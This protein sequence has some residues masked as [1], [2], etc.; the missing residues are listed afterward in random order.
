VSRPQA[1]AGP[2]TTLRKVSGEGAS[3]GGWKAGASGASGEVLPKQAIWLLVV[4]PQA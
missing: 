2:V 4:R 1:K 3:V